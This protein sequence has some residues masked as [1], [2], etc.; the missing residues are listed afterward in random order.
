MIDTDIYLAVLGYGKE[1]SVHNADLATSLGKL[2]GEQGISL[3]AGNVK[4]T[5]GFAFQAAQ[6]Y[7][8]SRI[9]II[10]RYKHVG[11]KHQATRVLRAPD[12]K[13]KHLQIAQTADAAILIGGG[14]GS[15]LLL[16]QFLKQ[17]KTVIAIRGSG[18]L[19]DSRLPKQVLYTESVQEAFEVLNS[20]KTQN[21]VQTPFGLLGLMY[22][23][24]ALCETILFD[25]TTQEREILEEG[26][27][28][29]IQEYFQGKRKEFDG[30]VHLCGTKFQR[31]VWKAILQIPY[32]KTMEYGELAKRINKSNAT[33]AVGQVTGQNPL[34]ILVPCHRLLGK[35]G[36]LVGYAGGLEMKMRLLD[37]ELKQTE[38]SFFQ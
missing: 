18:G 3:I 1:C 16:K 37:L 38:L 13:K 30:K 20:M 11:K 9:C 29:Q 17:K 28:R 2:A 7:A 5:F 36:S 21:T 12:T 10:E 32:G 31:E 24:F 35:D 14:P 23:H 27:A 33:R 22:N 26:F 4:A 15:R 34:W 19:A 25:S 8:V 6:D